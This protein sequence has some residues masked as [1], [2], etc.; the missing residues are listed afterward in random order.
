MKVTDTKSD[1]WSAFE[2]LPEVWVIKAGI[3]QEQAETTATVLEGHAGAITL[4]EVANIQEFGALLKNADGEVI[5]EIPA[6]SFIRAW[7]DENEARIQAVFLNRISKL[8]PDK[9]HEALE[10][11]ALWIQSDI[12]RRIRRGIGPKLADSTAARKKST[13]PL[14]D[15]GQLLAAILAKLDGKIAH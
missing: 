8:G 7:F 14:I 13:K 2:K 9:W 6:R 3:F 1:D 4:G 15:T 11:T 5:G 12:Q 10:Q